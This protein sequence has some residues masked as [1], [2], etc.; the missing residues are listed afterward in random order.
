MSINITNKM[1]TIVWN[2]ITNNGER[3]HSIWK[4]N[5]LW[6]SIRYTDK[7]PEEDRLIIDLAFNNLYYNSAWFRSM[8]DVPK[9]GIFVRNGFHFNN[10][11][12]DPHITFKFSGFDDAYQVDKQYYHAYFDKS[13]RLIKNMSYVQSIDL[14]V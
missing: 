10:Q 9:I 7:I 12:D 14:F 6:N 5:N 8:C 3:K 2:D 4:P 11:D 1:E 13:T